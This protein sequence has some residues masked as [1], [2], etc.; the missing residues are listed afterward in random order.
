MRA[1]RISFWGTMSYK[2]KS[3]KTYMKTILLC[4]DLDRTQLPNGVQSESPNARGFFSRLA[5]RQEIHL[6]HVTGRNEQLVKEAISKYDLP[7]PQFVIG[8][9]GTT[10]YR[11]NDSQWQL[12]ENWQQELGCRWPQEC[13]IHMT[14]FC[15]H[16]SSQQRQ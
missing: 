7:E 8:D 2:E 13:C 1:V 12:D 11:I 15:F 4:S 9:V 16:P 10:L 6:V 3:L 14:A 5:A